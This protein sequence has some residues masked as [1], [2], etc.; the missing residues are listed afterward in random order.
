MKIL[1]I[2]LQNINSL[3]SDSSIVIDFES[4]QFKGV[5]LYAITG[6]TG[7][8][9]TTILDAITIALYH[10]VPRFNGTKGTLIDVV[11]R[12]ANDA[13]SR[14]TFENNDS[15]YEGY[16]GIRLASKTGKLLSNPQEEVRLKN[17][18]EEKIIAEKK[19]KYIE[20]VE[21]VTQLD[22][23]QFLRSVMLAQGDFAAF[24]SAKGPDKGKLLEQITGE[25]IYKKIG[26]GIL[27]RKFAEERKLEKIQ[28]KI[29][30]E[31]ILTEEK[32]IEL[33]QKQKEL[34]VEIEASENENKSMERI[35][36]WYIESSKFATQSEQLEQDS[37]K[38]SSDLEKHK[39]EFEL[40]DLN[41][42][43]E[44][45]K[46]LIEGFDRTEKRSIDKSNDLK[47]LA[48]K[49]AELKP[50]IERLREKTGRKTA[51]LELAKKEFTDWL[52]KFDE[53]TKLDN[54]LNNEAEKKQQEAE[55]LEALNLQIKSLEDDNNELIKGLTETE[56]EI[57]INEA[58]ILK[59]EFL[60]TVNSEISTW[61]SKLTTLN[62]NKETLQ[63]DLL[64]ISRKKEKVEET[65]NELNEKNELFSEK[66]AAIGEIENELSALS[67]R[68][69]KNNLADLLAKKEKLS[70]IE[71]D[72]K[73]FKKFSEDASKKE[74]RLKSISDEKIAFSADLEKVKEK[75]G[76]KRK[77]IIFQEAFVVDAEKILDLEKSI[78]KY[79][80]D[81]QHLVKGQ[82]CGLCGSEEHPFAENEASIDISKS[83]RELKTRRKDL[84]KLSDSKSDLEK[85]EV[86]L[87]TNIDGCTAQIKT[88]TDELKSIQSNAK[89]LNIDCKLDNLNQIN[90]EVNLSSKNLKSLHDK[91]ISAQELQTQ[92]D[93]LST[94]IQ[95]QKEAVTTLKTTIATLNA[96][97]KNLN[98][99]IDTKHKSVDKLTQICNTSEDDLRKKL[100][101]FKYELPSIEQTSIFIEDIKKSIADFDKRQKNLAKLKAKINLIHSQLSSN[102]KQLAT[103]T[104]TRNNYAKTIAKCEDKYDT[105]QAKRVAILPIDISV[106]NKRSTLESARNKL[107]DKV[108][109]SKKELQK[110][111][112]TQVE[113]EAI[114]TKNIKEQK[115]LEEELSTLKASLKSKLKQ[116]DF[117]SK[118]DIQVALLSTE[119]KQKYTQNKERIKEQEIKLKTR[120]E[121][122]LKAIENLNQS[123]N[124]DTSEE[125]NQL[126]LAALKTKRDNLSAQKGE[127]KEAFRKDQE[128]KN[129]N[130][131]TYKKINA[132][133]EICKVW[134]ELFKIIGNSKDAFNIYVQRLTL[135]HLLNLANVH[136]FKLNK[137]YSLKMQNDYKPKEE[138]NFNLIDHYQTDQERL[139]DTSSGGE[140]FIISLALALGLSDLASKNVKINS[141]FID[142]GFG[143]LDSNTLETV[144]ST[145]ET[146]Q[147]QGKMIG[148]ISHVENL[149]ERIPTQIQIKKKSNGVSE[150][151]IL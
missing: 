112:D 149:K 13:F 76:T 18:S 68:L 59:N 96:D 90:I 144:I 1:K 148:I 85:K 14:V 109:S 15:I 150:V 63:Q 5:G 16:W 43:A 83:E 91:I 22:Y 4:E 34:D 52:P 44:P 115:D 72:W 130:Q 116:S 118:Q 95:A 77:E 42:Q 146:L 30:S 40:L 142:E 121:E 58:F 54:Q 9:K 134:R 21:K 141:L 81:R 122:N 111:L 110:L 87:S 19:R 131:E 133:E 132:Q 6:P 108:E 125:E 79:E 26:Q 117:Q 106:E 105:F 62:G 11:S 64:F 55:K 92:K 100:A 48:Q 78:S 147:S 70:A 32:E 27:D 20:E 60:S 80:A 3:K 139:V 33:T 107:A 104:K 51:Q 45:F 10:A 31:D 128:I 67:K 82:P 66:T 69:S 17:L 151:E 50:E 84:K 49:L 74:D 36:N 65:T 46:E 24:L 138:L 88:I 53:I 136:L 37:H 39:N 119:D 35:A 89:K 120:K 12:G 127:I 38:V 129:R 25:Q 71:S 23:N 93:E 114:R 102:K 61:V 94:D 75:I 2:E 137:R 113:K 124:F 145:L 123:K 29:N 126:A 98:A 28:T 41:E 143:T 73:Q 57:K 103:H 7:A 140:K 97:I 135:K 56:N 86:K 8:G 99:E 101:K 47:I